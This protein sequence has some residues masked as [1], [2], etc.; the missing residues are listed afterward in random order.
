MAAGLCPC[1]CRFGYPISFSGNL[2]GWG[3]FPG[4]FPAPPRRLSGR[5]FSDFS[6]PG[7]FRLIENR[8]DDDTRR[9][10]MPCGV[11]LGDAAGFLEELLVVAQRNKPRPQFVVIIDR[12]G[13]AE[14]H[15]IARLLE[16]LVIG[17]ER[18]RK[19]E[20]RGLQRV[21]DAHA[22]SAADVAPRRIAVSRISSC[23]GP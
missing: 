22:E 18:H 5:L 23:F 19:S 8:S 21:V 10:L 1:P 11:V 13:R 14:R 9:A 7:P 17:T 6:G 4:D 15:Q 2:S 3:F 16:F 20:R 12:P